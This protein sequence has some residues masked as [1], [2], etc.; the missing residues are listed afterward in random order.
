[1]RLLIVV[2]LLLGGGA[3]PEI[4]GETAQDRDLARL[5]AM[6]ERIQLLIG[7]A[8]CEADGECRSVPVGAKPCGGPRTYQ[9]YS[10]RVTDS[11]KLLKRVAAHR[12][13]DVELNRKYG[14]TS[15]CS[16][17]SEPAVSC[18]EGRCARRG[19]LSGR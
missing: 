19:G 5:R 11:G 6:E 9:I 3:P 4:T 18:R 14:W 12:A 8:T 1:M 2:A 15:D 17:V 7:A 13:L 16:V 10:T